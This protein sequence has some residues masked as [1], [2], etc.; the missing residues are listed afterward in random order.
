MSIEIREV[1]SR[2]KLKQFVC[3]AHKLYKNHPY[4]VPSLLKG[5]MTT[6]SSKSNPSFEHCDTLFLMAYKDGKAAGR[7]AGII[8]HHYIEQ[9]NKKDARFC[10]FDTIDD[11]EVTRSL[12]ERIEKWA[13]SKGMDRIIGPMGFTTFERQGMLV[14]G[15]EEIPTFAGCYNYPYYSDHLKQLGF[16]SEIQ[17]VEYEL[18]VP[19]E[20]PAK[21]MK[22]S[23]LIKKRYGLHILEVKKTKDMLPYAD[24]VFR[25]INASYKPLYGFTTLTEK[26]IAYF[27]KRFFGFIKPDYV[28]AVIDRHNNVLGFQ[29]SMP[30]LSKAL[31]RAK[32]RLLPLGWFHL[33]R[34]MRNP[35]RIDTLLTGVLPEYQG[36]GVNAVFMT[37]LTQAAINTGIKYAESNGELA[38]NIKVQNTWRYFERRQHRRSKIFARNIS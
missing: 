21:I 28:S 20:V 31:Q 36:K 7:I 16:E 12:F 1:N 30:S 2:R 15:F 23:N 11:P 13:A 19:H 3:F 6:L 33:R 25:V 18:K 5:E 24:P 10:W 9:W 34:A 37:H 14:S 8:N 27:V 22:I 17:Y 38:E 29:I 4:W 26:Q 32:G 35:E